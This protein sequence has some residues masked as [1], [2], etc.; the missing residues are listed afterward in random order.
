MGQKNPK[1]FFAKIS[2][3]DTAPRKLTARDDT[4][5]SRTRRALRNRHYV[6]TALQEQDE[7]LHKVVVRGQGG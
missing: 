3:I 5:T 7:W 1:W 6:M 4:V 2:K